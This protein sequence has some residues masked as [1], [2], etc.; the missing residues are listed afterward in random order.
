V[1]PT[2][3][4]NLRVDTLGKTL[5][6]KVIADKETG[7]PLGI[8]GVL[9]TE[10]YHAFSLMTD[11]LRDYPKAIVKFIRE[12]GSFLQQHYTA[13]YAVPAAYEINSRSCLELAGFR[14]L[15]TDNYGDVYRWSSSLPS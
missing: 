3:L 11:E 15:Y 1:G 8:A 12:F 5:R 6:G 7:E 9:H 14:Y 2:D 13:V 10:P 4:T